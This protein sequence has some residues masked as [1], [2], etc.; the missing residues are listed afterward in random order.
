MTVIQGFHL[1]NVAELF[2]NSDQNFGWKANGFG[3]QYS[4]KY[5]VNYI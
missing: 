2:K 4:N 5:L 3:Y 1:E